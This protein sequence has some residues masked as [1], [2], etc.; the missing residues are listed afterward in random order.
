MYGGQAV[1]I[2][3]A[4]RK[5]TVAHVPRV[6][7]DLPL[8][9]VVAPEEARARSSPVLRCGEAWAPSAA[10]MAKAHGPDS[11]FHAQSIMLINLLPIT[12]AEN[13]P[14]LRRASTSERLAKVHAAEVKVLV[15]FRLWVRPS[16]GMMR[17]RT[18]RP[19]EF[20]R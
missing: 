1:E 4:Y 7:A 12:V 13:C 18:M 10:I 11:P 17:L 14:N 16:L 5:D 20:T 6:F 15:R 9:D 3:H 19:E 2:T 8:F